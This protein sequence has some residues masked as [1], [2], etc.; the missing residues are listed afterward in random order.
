MRLARWFARSRPEERS[1]AALYETLVEHARSPAFYRAQGVPDTLDG[2]FELI[3]LH[4]FL[5]LHRLAD[6]PEATRDLGQALFDR[7]FADMDRNL[8]EMGAGDLGVGKRVRAMAEAFLGRIAAYRSG[9]V[10]GEAALRAALRRNLYGT[11]P[12]EPTSLVAM[13]AYVRA[14]LDT[15]QAQ[16][17]E[18]IR[19]GVIRFPPAPGGGTD[20]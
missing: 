4:A 12:L 10:D 1:A 18:A 8:R 14:T 16:D 20:D 19:A 11:V 15:L 17:M 6:A 2:R 3:A 13:A 5:V 9:L 7:L